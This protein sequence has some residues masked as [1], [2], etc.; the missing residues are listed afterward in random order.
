M[1]DAAF[2][3][4]RHSADPDQQAECLGLAMGW[5]AMALELEAHLRHL[6]QLEVSQARL[7]ATAT[8]AQPD[9]QL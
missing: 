1:A 2:L 5:H 7:R 8:D 9:Q 3:K 4:A 6:T